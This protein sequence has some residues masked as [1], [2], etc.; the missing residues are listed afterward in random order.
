MQIELMTRDMNSV[1]IVWYLEKRTPLS[2]IKAGL[3]SDGYRSQ[4]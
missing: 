3:K 1:Y 4:S 2:S